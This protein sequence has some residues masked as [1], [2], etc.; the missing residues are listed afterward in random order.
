MV[1]ELVS[2]YCSQFHCDWIAR[3]RS[4]RC[5]GLKLHLLGLRCFALREIT[6]PFRTKF[7]RSRKHSFYP[8]ACHFVFP[9]ISSLTDAFRT[10]TAL[11]PKFFV[12]CICS[13]IEQILRF[14][15]RLLYFL[16]DWIRVSLLDDNGTKSIFTSVIMVKTSK[17]RNFLFQLSS[18]IQIPLKR[19]F[20]KHLFIHEVRHHPLYSNSIITFGSSRFMLRCR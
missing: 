20:R 13:I 9:K 2:C 14:E 15:F 16:M 8:S 1:G 10:G 12:R 7:K 3:K 19:S 6:L 4:F 11:E 5:L 17:P 18:S